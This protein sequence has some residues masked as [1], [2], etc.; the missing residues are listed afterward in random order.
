M[1][2]AVI[3]VVHSATIFIVAIC[4]VLSNGCI[5]PA[6]LLFPV[7]RRFVMQLCRKNIIFGI[8]IYFQVSR[9]NGSN[10]LTLLIQSENYFSP[11]GCQ[12]ADSFL[13]F[14]CV[15]FLRFIRLYRTYMT[16]RTY[17]FLKKW[18]AWLDSNQRPHAYQACALT[19]WATGPIGK[20][21]NSETL[22]CWNSDFFV[23]F[24]EL[25]AF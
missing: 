5:T 7:Q 25:S 6:S 19:N 22:K 23:S 2:S 9:K 21:W 10:E 17:F 8:R 14:Y 1:K 16:Y 18:W 20:N 24:F 4:S 12:R 13:W 15:T 3:N 11:Y